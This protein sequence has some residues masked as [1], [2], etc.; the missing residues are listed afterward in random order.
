MHVA[1]LNISVLYVGF[2]AYCGL[3]SQCWSSVQYL[4]LLCVCIPGVMC[5]ISTE[6]WYTHL[7][8]PQYICLSKQ[9]FFEPLWYILIIQEQEAATQQQLSLILSWCHSPPV[10]TATRGVL[11][12]WGL[13]I[14]DVSKRHLL[15]LGM[16]SLSEEEDTGRRVTHAVDCPLLRAHW[17]LL[18]DD[19]GQG[20]VNLHPCLWSM[21]A[22]LNGLYIWAVCGISIHSQSR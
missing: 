16:N 15:H 21:P 18:S 10:Q 7:C 11:R 19:R 13:H 6:V 17:W 22:N 4:L 3:L 2:L 12:S 14:P 1:L 8:G 9:I 5:T 20:E